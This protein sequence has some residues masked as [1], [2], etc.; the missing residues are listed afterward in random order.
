MWGTVERKEKFGRTFY[1]EAVIREA[2]NALNHKTPTS[3]SRWQTKRI[4][5]GPVEWTFDTEDEFFD[6]YGPDASFAQIIAMVQS[7]GEEYAPTETWLRIGYS[8][9]FGT[10]VEVVADNHADLLRPFA[11]FRNNIEKYRLP[12]PQ[13]P[14]LKIFIGHG[15]S[16]DWRNLKDALQDHHGYQVE[17]FETKPRA[18][19][20][21]P[22]VIEGMASGNA[23]ALMV[24]TAEDE[25]IDGSVRAR[26]NVVHEVGYFQGR[27][28]NKRAILIMEDGV[29]EFSNIHGIVHVPYRNIKEVVGE[30]LGIIKR[31]FPYLARTG[32]GH[33]GG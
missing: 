26:E 30:V 25:Q 28:G 20:T 9:R 14:P 10:E 16:N 19:Y 24:L 2:F 18:G 23:L 3:V 12:E 22:E 13:L 7:S 8:P 4:H 27:L 32:H 5:R 21:I 1:P 11:P 33:W 15:R 6:Q 31:E 17:A 29:N